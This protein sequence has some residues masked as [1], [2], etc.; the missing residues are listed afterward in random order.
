MRDQRLHRIAIH[1]DQLAQEAY[2]EHLLAGRFFFHNDL[3][4]YLMGNI[5]TGLGIELKK[6]KPNYPTRI[7]T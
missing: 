4:E 1:A 6:V 2:R 3:G 5:S 7:R